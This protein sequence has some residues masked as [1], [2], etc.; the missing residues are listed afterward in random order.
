MCAPAKVPTTLSYHNRGSILRHPS[1]DQH[2]VCRRCP[3][4]VTQSPAVLGGIAPELHRVEL[5]ANDYYIIGV[6]DRIILSVEY[7]PRYWSSPTEG[8]VRVD[9]VIQPNGSISNLRVTRSSGNKILDDMTLDAVRRARFRGHPNGKPFPV[10]L[11][12]K[13]ESRKKQQTVRSGQ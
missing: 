8:T 7:F 13:F 10:A 5:S 11:P 4:A 9:F 6:R 3:G 1:Q 12:M 2:A